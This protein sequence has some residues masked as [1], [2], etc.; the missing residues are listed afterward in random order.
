MKRVDPS[1]SHLS[2]LHSLLVRDEV[3]CVV[4]IV[5]I[6]FNSSWKGKVGSSEQDISL[7]SSYPHECS[8]I[9]AHFRRAKSKVK[10]K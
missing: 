8:V 1:P 9:V 10:S 2:E 6:D 3:L 7:T 4:E 5:G